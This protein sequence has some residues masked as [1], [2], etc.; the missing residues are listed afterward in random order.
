MSKGRHSAKFNAATVALIWER[1]RG[2]CALCGI[3]LHFPDRGRSWSIH[4]RRPRGMGG[5][6][7]AWVGLAANGLTLCGSGVDGCHGWVE[8]NRGVA[9]EDGLLVSKLGYL[10]AEDVP[11]RLKDGLWKLDNHGGKTAIK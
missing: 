5:T 8:T 6:R 9:V 7:T 11:V 4:H 3:G 1:D 10:T 2:R